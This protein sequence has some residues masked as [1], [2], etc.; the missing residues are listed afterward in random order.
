[1]SSL[2]N[3]R[4]LVTSGTDTRNIRIIA[5]SHP[6]T[7]QLDIVFPSSVSLRTALEELQCTYQT[8]ECSLSD[9]LQFAKPH[10]H[11]LATE[12]K[13][14][15]HGLAG[16]T[17]SDVWC[18]DSRGVLTLAVSKQTYEFLGLVGERLPWK[19]CEDI[20]VI[21]IY[22]GYTGPRHGDM[23][24]WAT[25]GAKEAAI[26]RA[27]DERRG[28]WKIMYHMQNPDSNR[29]A[30][31]APHQIEKTV[32]TR[33]HVHIPELAR[34]D[35]LNE[36]NRLDDLE[37]WEDRVSSLFEWVGLASLGSQRL[38]AN[39]RCDPYISVYEPPAPSHVGELTVMRWRGFLPS[40]FVQSILDVILSPNTSP[41]D[42]VSVTANSVPTSP[43]TYIPKDLGKAPPLRAPRPDSEDTWSVLYARA[44]EPTSSWWIAAES[45]GRWDRRW[46]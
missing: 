34:D 14:V 39:D 18:L 44:S 30:Q 16:S 24:K 42:F 17:D 27:W 19:G 11:H 13:V 37:S 8:C 32:F 36:S 7:Q 4:C 2:E 40:S 15:A 5:Q 46:G 9:F 10:L 3:R 12:S 35:L 23:K 1:M 38:L 26:L 25:Y 6:F 43:V 41:P 31:S 21:H 45:V 20:H 29:P 22:I 33:P 28:P